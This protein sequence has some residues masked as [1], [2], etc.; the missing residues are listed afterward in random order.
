MAL[1]EMISSPLEAGISIL[2]AHHLPPHLTPALEYVSDKL[3]RKS[4]YLTLVAVRRDYQLPTVIPP[5]GSPGMQ[6]SP[7]PTTPLSPRFSF[8]ASPVS[9]LR[10]LVRSG[11][12]HGRSP[13]LKIETQQLRGSMASPTPSFASSRAPSSLGRMSPKLQWPLSPASMSPMT[14]CTPSSATTTSTIASNDVA[15]PSPITGSHGMRLVY[16]EEVSA[17]D[18]KSLRT[19]IHNARRKFRIGAEWLSEPVSSTTCG[20]TNQLIQRSMSQNEVLFSSDGLVLVA[21]DGLY[22][23]KSALS[24]YSKT[25]SPL[26]LEDAVDEL[27]RLVLAGNGRKVT[28]SDLLRSYD[29]LSVSHAAIGELDLMYRRAYGGP[30]GLG[31]ITGIV[32]TGVRTVVVTGNDVKIRDDDGDRATER[33]CVGSPERDLAPPT[34]TKEEQEQALA[35]PFLPKLQTNFD[36]SA[37]EENSSDSDDEPNSNL[38]ARPKDRLP[39]KVPSWRNSSIDE[40]MLSPGSDRSSPD[41]GPVTPNEYEDISPVTR[42]E[43][44]FLMVDN[45]LRVGRTV[46]VETC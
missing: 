5:C 19:I 17:K 29:W 18:D 45:S 23:L 33:T 9:S 31:A 27:R 8:T 37:N 12:N 32:P 20:L 6:N 21:L 41:L 16:S 28:R 26:R 4:I 1:K 36:T 13:R 30:E 44:G 42:G 35:M 40:T 38:T 24:A 46:A 2:D 43:W 7:I 34:E 15:Y 39:F 10:Q 25:R 22:S 3:A 14:P 11:S